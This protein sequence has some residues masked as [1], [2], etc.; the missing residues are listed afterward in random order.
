MKKIEAK[1]EKMIKKQE[2]VE[3]RLQKMAERREF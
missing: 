2:I 1:K 3:K